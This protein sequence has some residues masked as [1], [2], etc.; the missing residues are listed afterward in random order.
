M[1]EAYLNNDEL[2]KKIKCI[3]DQEEEQEKESDEED[4]GDAQ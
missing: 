4:V 3:E 2:F 1:E